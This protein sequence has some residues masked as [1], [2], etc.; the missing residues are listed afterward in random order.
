MK[1]VLYLTLKKKW[2]DR[3]RSGKKK[4]E[5]RQVKPYWI[6]RLFDEDGVIRVWD[7]VHFRNGYG[8]DKPLVIAEWRGTVKVAGFYQ[9][10]IG[11]LL[12]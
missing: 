5:Y 12:G 6:K 11:K 7:E 9:I 8:K 10:H 1:R 4:V 3:I 2:F